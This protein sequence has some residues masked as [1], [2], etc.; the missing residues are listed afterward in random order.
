MSEPEKPNPEPRKLTATEVTEL[1]VL[2]TRLNDAFLD[3]EYYSA[4]AA[5]LV[6]PQFRDYFVRVGEHERSVRLQTAAMKS[7]VLP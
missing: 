3:V 7:E 6:A 4:S 2:F 1:Q 5:R